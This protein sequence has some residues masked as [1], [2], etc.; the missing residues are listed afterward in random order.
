MVVQAGRNPE[1]LLSCLSIAA[2][3]SHYPHHSRIDPQLTLHGVLSSSSLAPLGTQRCLFEW[4]HLQHQSAFARFQILVLG[5]SFVPF[6]LHHVQRTPSTHD[7]EA[8]V[9]RAANV[10]ANTGLTSLPS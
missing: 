9:R 4:P 10:S 3:E 5:P 7:A 1:T 6:D 2:T 8:R